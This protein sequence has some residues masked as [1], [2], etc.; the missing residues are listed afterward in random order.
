MNPPL[1]QVYRCAPNL[2]WHIDIS[3]SHMTLQQAWVCNE[4]G[5][6]QWRDLEVATEP[7]PDAPPE[8]LNP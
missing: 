1:A 5:D 4:T 7:T 3:K 6:V 2:R 8:P